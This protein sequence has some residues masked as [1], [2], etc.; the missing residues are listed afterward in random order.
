MAGFCPVAGG[1]NAAFTVFARAYPPTMLGMGRNELRV[2]YASGKALFK[3]V[4]K[5]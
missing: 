2:W 5:G 3:P 4:Q 1:S